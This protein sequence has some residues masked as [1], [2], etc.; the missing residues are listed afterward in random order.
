MWIRSHLR[1]ELDAAPGG[2]LPRQRLRLASFTLWKEGPCCQEQWGDG[3]LGWQG[4]PSTLPTPAGPAG[5]QQRQMTQ[6]QGKADEPQRTE[7]G[8]N[9]QQPSEHFLGGWEEKSVNPKGNQPWIWRCSWSSN[10]LAMWCKDLTHWERLWCW[11]RLRAEREG[12][13]RKRL[14]DGITD[15]MHMNLSKRQETAKDKEAWRAIVHGVEK[16]WTLLSNWTK[17]WF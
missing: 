6:S 8:S 12:V 3:W 14:L 16:S 7:L 13:Q 2:L 1:W 9:S 10:T 5:S 11:E 15:S 4:V 17:R